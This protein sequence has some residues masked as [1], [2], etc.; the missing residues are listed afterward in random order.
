MSI[1]RTPVTADLETFFA[2]FW[3]RRDDVLR[4]QW[5]YIERHEY[6]IQISTEE[7]NFIAFLCRLIGAKRVLEIGT[8][9]GTSAIWIAR[10][11]P[12]DGKLETC[13]ID[14]ARA[15]QAQ[16]WFEKAKVAE[17]VTVHIGDALKIME[18]LSGPYDLIFLD[19]PK[20]NCIAQLKQAKRLVRVNGLILLDNAFADGN[21]HRISD[22]NDDDRPAYLRAIATDPDLDSVVLAV[23]DGLAISRRTR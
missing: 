11:L 9:Y 8:F 10:A 2:P 3:D 1:K 22:S 19:G 14:P 6:P 13:E 23:A 15:Q 7:A 20:N 17:K 5:E 12:E 16:V 18:T 4:E 21:I